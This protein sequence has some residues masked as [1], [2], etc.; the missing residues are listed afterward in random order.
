MMRQCLGFEKCKQAKKKKSQEGEQVGKGEFLVQR[1]A[2]T[3]TQRQSG[4]RR[5]RQDSDLKLCTAVLK[6]LSF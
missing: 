1:T 2:C 4:H 6:N 3:K 5:G